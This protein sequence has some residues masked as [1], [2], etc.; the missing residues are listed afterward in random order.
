MGDFEQGITLGEW[1]LCTR[2]WWYYLASVASHSCTEKVYWALFE[3]EIEE[4]RFVCTNQGE[5]SGLGNFNN[6]LQIS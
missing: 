3:A 4:E 1:L 2:L 6:I 5:G